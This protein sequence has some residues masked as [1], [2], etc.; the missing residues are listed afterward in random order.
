MLALVYCATTAAALGAESSSGSGHDEAAVL[1]QLVASIAFNHSR[2]TGHA[3]PLFDDWSGTDPCS[4]QLWTGVT[5]GTASDVC[6]GRVTRLDLGRGDSMWGVLP[7]TP[8]MTG[9][10]TD[11]PRS[12]GGLQCLRALNL[13][14]HNIGQLP[15]EFGELRRLESL[16][17]FRNELS[18]ATQLRAVGRLHN[19]R[20]L[21]LSENHLLDL[22]AEFCGLRRLERLELRHTNLRMLT[23]GDDHARATG[24]GD[25]Q[26]PDDR[27]SRRGRRRDLSCLTSLQYLDVSS[28]NL[29]ALPDAIGDLRNLTAL[30]LNNTGAKET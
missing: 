19:L 22:P 17:L 16:D 12:I 25:G 18:D 6:K 15:T 9:L 8:H 23:L 26:L 20:Q 11:L 24:G 5:C 3:Q 28:N 4:G 27:R 30:N 2:V 1:R 7:P 10:L 21:R 14:G 29:V 13:S